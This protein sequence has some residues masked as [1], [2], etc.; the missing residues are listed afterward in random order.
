MSERKDGKSSNRGS[1]NFSQVNGGW[2]KRDARSGR[3]VEVVSDKGVSRAKPDSEAAIEKASKDRH[4]AL[5]RLAN[6]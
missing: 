2:I 1:M 6:R 5:K 3:F 4:D